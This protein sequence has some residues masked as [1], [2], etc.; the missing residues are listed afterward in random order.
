MGRECRR[1]HE[2][3]EPSGPSSFAYD[4]LTFFI[5]AA[6]LDCQ[7]CKHRLIIEQYDENCK[8]L[9]V[10]EKG[11]LVVDWNLYREKYRESYSRQSVDSRFTMD[12]IVNVLDRLKVLSTKKAGCW[13][14]VVPGVWN[15]LPTLIGFPIYFTE[16]RFASGYA[17]AML[18]GTVV[19]WEIKQ[20]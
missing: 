11:R 20:I 8:G 2:Q 16:E 18:S 4:G 5:S 9:V 15:F 19:S 12:L 3:F 17:K 13:E 6:E 7:K 1:C 10:M 14:V